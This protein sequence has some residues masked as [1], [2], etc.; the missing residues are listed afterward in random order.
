MIC[1]V[2]NG[3]NLDRS[4]YSNIIDVYDDALLIADQGSELPACR[5]AIFLYNHTINH[6]DKIL[7]KVNKYSLEEMKIQLKQKKMN[8]PMYQKKTGNYKIIFE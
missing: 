7:L 1:Y 3:C 8:S 4:F 6:K 2:N 5:R